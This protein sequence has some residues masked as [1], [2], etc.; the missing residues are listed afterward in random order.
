[1]IRTEETAVIQP[2]NERPAKVWSAGGS[3]YNDISR[4]IAD[5]IEHCVLRLNP[6]PGERILDL[7]TGT[8]WTSRL[9]AR[10]GATV[11]GVDI[12]TGL[13]EAEQDG[14]RELG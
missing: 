7:A 8:G 9:V 14:P 11:T 6:R 5:S 4:G 1:M 2:H 13:L 12:A 3:N 10:R